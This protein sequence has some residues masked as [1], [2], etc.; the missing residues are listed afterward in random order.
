MWI[1]KQ[2][3]GTAWVDNPF[4]TWD[5]AAWVVRPLKYWN[6]TTWTTTFLPTPLARTDHAVQSSHARGASGTAYTTGSLSLPANSLVLVA[7][8]GVSNNSAALRPTGFTLANSA[9]LA[10]ANVTMTGN[11]AQ[12]GYGVS[13]WQTTTTTAVSSTF[14]VQAGGNPVQT[15]DVVVKSWT[16]YNATTPIGGTALGTDANGTGAASITLSAAPAAGDETVSFL[17]GVVNSGSP[18]VTA[19]A[20]FANLNYTVDAGWGYNEVASRAGSTSTTVAWGDV[21]VGGGPLE[22]MLAAVVVKAA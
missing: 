18:T 11:P 10:M 12:W 22:V 16:G 14:T 20:G 6:G 5:G 13:I 15:W 4:K 1:G 2:W 9:G 17:A 8:F 19:G 7:V 3:S 21:G